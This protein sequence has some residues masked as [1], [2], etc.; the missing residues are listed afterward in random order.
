V[1]TERVDVAAIKGLLGRLIDVGVQG[2]RFGRGFY[3]YSAGRRNGI[4]PIVAEVVGVGAAVGDAGERLLLALA[5][6]SMLCW[7]DGTLCHPD[8]GDLAS[9]LCIG[10]P[11]ALGGP[12]HRADKQ[13][14][15]LPDGALPTPGLSGFSGGGR[16]APAR[17]G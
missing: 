4:D 3:R 11:R 17:R 10:F 5:T 15:A 7:D 9:V 1:L 12:F 2:K 6:E 8:D 13:G 16:V 14:R